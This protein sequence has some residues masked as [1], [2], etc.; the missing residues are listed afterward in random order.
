MR[1]AYGFSVEG[2]PTHSVGSTECFDSAAFAAQDL[3]LDSRDGTARWYVWDD[4]SGGTLVHGGVKYDESSDEFLLTDADG[5]V[6]G[7]D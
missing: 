6:M 2:E 5:E 7:D 3:A 4:E 1:Y